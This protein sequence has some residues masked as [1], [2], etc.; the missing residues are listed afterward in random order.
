MENILINRLNS[1]L[2]KEGYL[3][4]EEKETTTFIKGKLINLKDNKEMPLDKISKTHL[5]NII[6]NKEVEN[7]IKTLID[8][9]KMYIT[10]FH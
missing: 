4:L 8:N 10:L 6:N 1:S 2:K 3:F 5:Y 9:Y 7:F